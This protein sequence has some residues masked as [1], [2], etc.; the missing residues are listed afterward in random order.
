MLFRSTLH[1]TDGTRPWVIPVDT[2]RLVREAGLVKKAVYRPSKARRISRLAA[3]M[4]PEQQDLALQVGASGLPAGG[5]PQAVPALAQ[6]RILDL[7]TEQI[8]FRY[9]RKELTQEEY[10][11]QYR[12]VLA[13]RSKLGRPAGSDDREPVPERPDLGHGSNRL[14]LGGGVWKSRSFAELK[15]RPAFHHLQ[16]PDAGYLEGSQIDFLNL[17]LRTYPEEGKAELHALDLI[18]IV[19]LSPR[20]RR[21]PPMTRPHAAR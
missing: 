17:V 7:A 19:S 11:R 1:L 14:A 6:S 15:I 13:A 21:L 3:Q 20:D 2:V 9:F 16:D 5:L 10:Q 18:N 4:T 8:E 12:E